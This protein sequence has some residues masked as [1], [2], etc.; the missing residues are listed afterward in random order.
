MNNIERAKK[1]ITLLYETPDGTVGGYGHVVFDDHNIE[2]GYING[3]IDDAILN[4]YPDNICS[5][6]R[7]ASL[8]ALYCFLGLT[9]TSREIVLS[10]L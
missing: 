9:L 1:L 7:F 3:C 5:E 6:T 10:E 8:A 2:D 4:R